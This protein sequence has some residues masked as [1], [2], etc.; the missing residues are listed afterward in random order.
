MTLTARNRMPDWA[1]RETASA[2]AHRGTHLAPDAGSSALFVSRGT[3][4]L[5]DGQGALDVRAG[6]A[7]VRGDRAALDSEASVDISKG[8]GTERRDV[9]YLTASGTLGVLEGEPGNFAWGDGIGRDEQTIANAYRPAPPDMADVEGY[10]L[11]VVTVTQNAN[12][13]STRAI[14]ELRAPAPTSSARGDVEFRSVGTPGGTTNGVYQIDPTMDD[15][16]A[17][18]RDALD[19]VPTGGVIEVPSVEFSGPHSPVTITKRFVTIKSPRATGRD[20]WHDSPPR[21]H[22]SEGMAGEP[23]ITVDANAAIH[24]ITFDRTSAPRDGAPAIKAHKAMV[25]DGVV[26]EH[27]SGPVISLRCENATGT[28]GVNNSIVRNAS[29]WYCDSDV[30]RSSVSQNAVQN[31][32][33]L[34]VHVMTAKECDGFA[35]NFE[36]GWGN[37]AIIDHTAGSSSAGAFRCNGFHNRAFLGYAADGLSHGVRFDGHDSHAVIAHLGT[38][39]GV[40]TGDWVDAAGQPTNGNTVDYIGESRWMG[41][42]TFEG[43][44]SIPSGVIVTTPDGSAQYRLRVDNAGNVVSDQV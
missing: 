4:T 15:F 2:K 18:L 32:N 36:D 35:V 40:A 5:G 14:H 19:A 42:R 41:A 33:A 6:A 28:D 22:D 26:G 11:A 7:L 39:V 23:F 8:S 3:G 43:D 10:P 9:V 37:D 13:L 34:R 21:V 27:I 44:L 25:S 38:Y 24:D 16:G 31:A 29:G 12:S 30:V 17:A 20:L 1:V